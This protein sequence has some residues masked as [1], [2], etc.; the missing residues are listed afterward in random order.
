MLFFK[1][2]TFIL[3]PTCLNSNFNNSFFKWNLNQFTAEF[4]LWSI[5]SSVCLFSF[6]LFRVRKLRFIF[7]KCIAL[8]NGIKHFLKIKK[9]SKKMPTSTSTTVAKLGNPTEGSQ[10]T[11]H[12]TGEPS[13]INNKRFTRIYLTLYIFILTII[14]SCN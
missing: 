11:I 13:L 5:Q 7:L 12:G 14:N 1:N 9:A 10:Q 6:L 3:I 8:S 4:N 2:P